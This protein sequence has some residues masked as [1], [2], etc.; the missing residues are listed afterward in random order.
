MK[1]TIA[2][3]IILALAIPVVAL[4]AFAAMVKAGDNA[5]KVGNKY[6]PVSGEAVSGSDFVVYQ[7][8]SYG[9][10]C[11]MCKKPFLSDPAKY[12]AKME[13]QE[14]AGGTSKAAAGMKKKM[15]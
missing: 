5:V 14:A 1:K 3:F 9:L 15:G 2:L 11:P 7:G 4:P 12:I 13:K 6:C 10:C 8:K